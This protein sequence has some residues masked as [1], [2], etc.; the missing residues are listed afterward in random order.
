M[1]IDAENMLSR[2]GRS[3]TKKQNKWR[4]K[5]RRTSYAQAQ[6]SSFFILRNKYREYKKEHTFNLNYYFGILGYYCYYKMVQ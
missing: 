1:D 6:K 5:N 2:I 3:Q 4:F